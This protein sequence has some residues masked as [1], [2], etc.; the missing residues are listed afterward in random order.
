LV[1]ASAVSPRRVIV[2]GEPE[3]PPCRC[4]VCNGISS[5]ATSLRKSSSDGG[6]AAGRTTNLLSPAEMY[7][8]IAC[9]AAAQLAGTSAAGSLPGRR[10]RIARG[11]ARPWLPGRRGILGLG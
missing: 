10:W 1:A 7:C 11:R 4:Q 2:G 9:L 6:D 5:R 3:P 8:S